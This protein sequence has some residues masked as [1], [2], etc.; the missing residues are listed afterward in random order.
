MMKIV[1]PS[2][3]RADKLLKFN[4]YEKAGV[5]G[6]WIVEP[7]AKLVSVFTLQESISTIFNF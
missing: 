5:K 1:S 2:T 4:M 6:Y 7:E 3:A